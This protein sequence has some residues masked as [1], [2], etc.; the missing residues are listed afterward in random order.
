[1]KSQHQADRHRRGQ[2]RPGRARQRDL[3][4]LPDQFGAAE[5]MPIQSAEISAHSTGTVA[6]GGPNEPSAGQPKRHLGR[7]RSM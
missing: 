7:E 2:I 4:A 1:M 5:A 6:C 3:H